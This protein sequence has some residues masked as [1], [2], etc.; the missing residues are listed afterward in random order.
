MSATRPSASG[1]CRLPKN[2]L[3]KTLLR[4]VYALDQRQSIPVTEL[5]NES[6]SIVHVEEALVRAACAGDRDAFGA[7]FRQQM[8]AP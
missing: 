4:D 1:P 7:I 8:L 5:S 2:P 3:N 6:Q